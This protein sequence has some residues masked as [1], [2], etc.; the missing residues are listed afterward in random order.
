MWNWGGGKSNEEI[1]PVL[2]YE[3]GEEYVV[4]SDEHSSVKVHSVTAYGKQSR[5]SRETEPILQT[6]SVRKRRSSRTRFCHCVYDCLLIFGALICLAILIYWGRPRAPH[7]SVSKASLGG[8]R[9]ST[10]TREKRLLP[11]VQLDVEVL[12]AF[13]VHNPNWAGFEYKEITA[14]VKYKEKVI[15][16]MKTLKT[17]RILPWREE[18]V[19][20]DL[21]LKGMQLLGD[22][23]DLLE[24]TA[25][26]KVNLRVIAL[27]NGAV[28]VSLWSYNTK[29]QVACN[30]T[31]DPLK[32]LLLDK[33]CLSG[34]VG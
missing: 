31:V 26:G 18:N 25:K 19:D 24:D 13:R 23:P 4:G 22:G 32:K 16:D 11:D 21:D 20:A 9:I 6:Y 1:S 27:I 33:T 8:I 15:G 34:I 10:S 14:S 3:K 28:D 5:E 2:A 30:I 12:I 29:I 17:G 7:I